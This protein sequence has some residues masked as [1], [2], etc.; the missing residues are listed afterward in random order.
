MRFRTRRW[1][2]AEGHCA[3]RERR[4]ARGSRRLWPCSRRLKVGAPEE[5]KAEVSDKGA[6]LE[7]VQAERMRAA[8]AAENERVGLAKMLKETV[9]AA[10]QG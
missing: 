2:G 9:H 7:V 5:A 6:T 4:C 8:E 10:D 1:A 3:R